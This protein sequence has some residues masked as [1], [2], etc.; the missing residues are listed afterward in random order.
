MDA[1]EKLFRAFPDPHD[2]HET[3]RSLFVG[4]FHNFNAHLKDFLNTTSDDPDHAY[5][6]KHADAAVNGDYCND[7][8]YFRTKVLLLALNK[9]QIP[10]DGSAKSKHLQY[11]RWIGQGRKDSDSPFSPI[12]S[13][14]QG[15]SSLAYLPAS[16]LSPQTCANCGGAKSFACTGCLLTVDSGHVIFKTVYCSKECQAAHWPQHKTS[17]IARKMIGRAAFLLRDL[18]VLFQDLTSLRNLTNFHEKNGV[19]YVF[20][21]GHEEHAFRGLP[22]IREF[23]REFASTEDDHRALVT[24]SQCSDAVSLFKQTAQLFLNGQY[25][26]I[27]LSI[28]IMAQQLTEFLLVA[29]CP[30]VEEVQVDPRNVYRPIFGFIYEGSQTAM[31]RTHFMLRVRLR[32]GEE[33]AIDLAGAQYGWQEPLGPWKAWETQRVYGQVQHGPIGS[34]EVQT[35]ARF[36]DP[37]RSAPW[38]KKSIQ[39]RQAQADRMLQ[40]IM[41]AI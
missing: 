10:N 40:A 2:D 36:S 17:C 6:K 26:R 32:S 5:F 13:T 21:K 29:F 28:L 4:R 19:L 33:V 7:L 16:L 15:E 12:A 31:L 39:A 18:F 34:I 27:P 41:G 11:H 38:Q 14:G 23:P 20:D 30:Q 22:V 25:A 24:D 3:Y 9:T 37:S 1:V 8:Q 35:N